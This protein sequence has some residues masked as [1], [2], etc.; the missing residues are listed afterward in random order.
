MGNKVRRRRAV[1]SKEKQSELVTFFCGWKEGS[2][3]HFYYKDKMSSCV[4]DR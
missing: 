4:P 2:I 1:S 3:D